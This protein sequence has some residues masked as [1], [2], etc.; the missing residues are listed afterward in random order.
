VQGHTCQIRCLSVAFPMKEGGGGTACVVWTPSTMLK[1]TVTVEAP[2]S[3]SRLLSRK[4]GIEVRVRVAV[5]RLLD[6]NLVAQT[7]TALAQIEA[8]WLDPDHRHKEPKPKKAE[9]VD[10]PLGAWDES[11]DTRR[12]QLA[13]HI[14]TFADRT[15]DLHH[16]AL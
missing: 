8:S 5:H 4:R 9:P 15:W 1:K 6:I 16:H 13:G 14:G 11:A 12:L 3:A 2:G 10:H 7:F